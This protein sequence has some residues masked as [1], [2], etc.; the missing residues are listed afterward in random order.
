VGTWEATVG[1]PVRH[2]S[3]VVERSALC[4]RYLIDAASVRVSDFAL[5]IFI[6]N[7]VGAFIL[8]FLGGVDYRSW[9]ADPE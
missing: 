6:I 5:D 4:L 1:T 7:V 8:A 9:G 2:W 3:S